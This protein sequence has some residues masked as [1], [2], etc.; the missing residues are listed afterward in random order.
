MIN[1]QRFGLTQVYGWLRTF[2]H[3]A[4]YEQI[5]Q[6]RPTKQPDQGRA[7]GFADEKEGFIVTEKATEP[8]YTLPDTM[9][10]ARIFLIRLRII[11]MLG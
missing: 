5:L 4:V 9:D 10:C 1:A 11:N 6:R 8:A 2:Q 3:R 7:A